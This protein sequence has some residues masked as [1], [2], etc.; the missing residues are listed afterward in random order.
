M[1]DVLSVS[2]LAT[3]P[4]DDKVSLLMGMLRHRLSPVMRSQNIRLEWEICDLPHDFLLQDQSRLELMRL[5]QE[6]FANI[7]K[8]A[9][10]SVVQFKIGLHTHAITIDIQDNGRGMEAAQIESSSAK[11]HGVKNMHQRAHKIGAT[12]TIHSTAEGTGIHLSF[13]RSSWT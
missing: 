11:G 12:L 13:P 5:L 10:A 8:H 3:E 6:A 9:K 7:I 4:D 1:M 2:D